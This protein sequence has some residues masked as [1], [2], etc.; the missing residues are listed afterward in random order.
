M[1]ITKEE[2]IKFLN[3][4]LSK[5]YTAIVQYTQHAGVLTGAAY[6]DI[7][8]ELAV[9]ANEELQHALTLADQIDYLGGV[10]IVDVVPAKISQDNIKMLEQDL[11]GENDA[12]ARYIQRI[13]QAEELKLLALAQKLREILI[14]EQEHAM[15]LE[16]ALGK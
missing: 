4:D 5:E 6:G 13:E 10:P 2:L 8:K 9:H 16:Q 15:D 11:E 12:I 7:K 14:V 1:S 3:I